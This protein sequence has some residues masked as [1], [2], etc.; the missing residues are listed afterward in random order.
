MRIIGNDPEIPRQT[1]VIASGAITGGKPVAVN[2][3]G[4][5]S[6]VATDLPL[7]GK[8]LFET[9]GFGPPKWAYDSNSDRYVLVY[10]GSG[11]NAY[12]TARVVQ[13]SGTTLSMGAEFTFSSVAGTYYIDACFDSNSN[14]IVISYGG[15]TSA[16]YSIVA[17]VTA[18]DNTLAFGTQNQFEANGTGRGLASAFDSNSN[19]VVVAF[20]DRNDSHRGK[21]VVGTVSGTN[22]SHGSQVQFHAEDTQYLTIVFDDNANKMVIA[23]ANQPNNNSATGNAVVGT[24][25]G[26]GIS[27]GSTATFH[28]NTGGSNPYLLS[29]VYDLGSC[30]DTTSNRFVLAYRKGNDPANGSVIVG[31]VSG[32]NISFGTVV[33]YDASHGRYNAV[34][35][36]IEQNKIILLYNKV[37]DS[38]KGYYVTGTVNN[39][40]ISVT[41]PAR[42]TVSTEGANDIRALYNN[43]SK[44]TLVAYR[45]LDSNAASGDDDQRVF[46]LFLGDSSNISSYIGIAED[47]VADGQPV[48]VNTKGA[49]DENQSSLTAG[50]LYFVQTDGTLDIAADTTSVMAGTAVSATKLIV[51]G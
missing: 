14:K 27:F 28:A 47:T 35:H 51:K 8:T 25:S 2:T 49:V 10:P 6:V 41:T 19:K 43:T 1:Q 37:D 9:N 42:F 17:T 31:T 48:I 21:A 15:T 50:Q 32:T 7:D 36:D 22:I 26:T 45:S 18:G 29:S 11:G 20:S 3:D 34:T 4:T 12:G 33:Q 24:V 40:A 13:I 5:V 44:K 46:G 38:G 39:T 23:Y 30:F 16:L